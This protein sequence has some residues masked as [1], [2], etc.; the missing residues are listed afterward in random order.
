MGKYKQHTWPGMVT[1]LV[2]AP[3][4][5][6]EEQTCCNIPPSTALMSAPLT[7]VGKHSLFTHTH[8]PHS[9]DST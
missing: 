2:E 4:S 9:L 7:C 6:D 1:R 8:T 3:P 5:D